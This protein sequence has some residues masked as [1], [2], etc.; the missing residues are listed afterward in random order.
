MT[1]WQQLALAIAALTSGNTFFLLGTDV[2]DVVIRW[3]HM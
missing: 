3:V 2:M 1:D